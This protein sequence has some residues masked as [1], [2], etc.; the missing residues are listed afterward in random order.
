LSD[1][2]IP[3]VENHA[4]ALLKITLTPSRDFQLGVSVIFKLAWVE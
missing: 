1:S 2:E 3:Q 4:H